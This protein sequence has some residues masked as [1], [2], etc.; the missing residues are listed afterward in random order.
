MTAVLTAPRPTPA[1]AAP[2]KSRTGR[3][4][5]VIVLA[6]YLAVGAVMVFGFD[7]IMEDALSRVAAASSVWWSSDPK[8]AAIGYVWTPLPALL[9]VPFT[10]LRALWPGLV[11]TGWL[12][13][14]LSAA[15]MAGAVAVLHGILT[16]L[17]V[18]P[19]A[20]L[21]VTVL[22]ALQPLILI[23]SA[24]G[25]TEALLMVC[26]LAAV[27]SL[28]R[29]LSTGDGTQLVSAGLFLGLGY[30]A[31]Y[32]A[33]VAAAAATLLVMAVSAARTPQA[34]RV[35]TVVSDALLVGLPAVIAFVVWAIVSWAVVG[36]PFE[37][38]TSIYGNSALVAGAR[39][40]GGLVTV[41]SQLLWLVPLAAPLL[42]VVAVRAV[43]R[44]DPAV[45]APVAVFG[46][47]LAFEWVLNL[48]GSLFGF[49]RYQIMVIPLAA[50]LL[51][52][53]LAGPS[54]GAV[55]RR[56]GGLGLIVAVLGSAAISSGVLVLT[57]PVLAS[58][59]YLR[60]R[61]VLDAITHSANG[62]A[63]A[64]GMWAQDRALAAWLDSLHLPQASVLADTGTAFAVVAASDNPRQFLITS[65]DGFDAALA[66]PPAHG[67][68]YLLRNEHGG[69]DTVRTRW[70]DL[71][72]AT[73][74]VWATQVAA[75]PGASQWSYGW[76]V[77]AVTPAR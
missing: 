60:V 70:A 42:L 30:L 39:S 62:D 74:P 43:R 34:R 41:G 59:E 21:L 32:E 2:P 67:I 12:A 23:Y 36:S 72:T 37:Q 9:M 31:R 68:R 57:Q 25:M 35:A 48:A 71:G 13:V 7:S 63:G 26:L 56:V 61:P 40:G 28:L 73:G 17:R 20:R 69:I 75:Y 77:W 18:R 16:D 33:I 29:W 49:L 5:F 4:V 38:F 24:N 10:P 15:A 8:L 3:R 54:L 50:V 45:L 14:M 65:D 66:D 51:G 19:S 6:C 27:R 47:V 1:Q 52:L 55:W 22:F 58:Q 53:L 76:T 46:A 44:H 64:N 11:F